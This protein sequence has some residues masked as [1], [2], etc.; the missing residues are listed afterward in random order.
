MVSEHDSE[1]D[2]ILIDIRTM[3][4]SSVYTLNPSNDLGSTLVSSSQWGQLSN[5]VVSDANSVTS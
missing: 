3:D 4:T 2:L 5:L 1:T